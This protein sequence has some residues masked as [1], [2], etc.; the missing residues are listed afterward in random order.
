MHVCVHIVF[1]LLCFISHRR[2]LK[3]FNVEGFV[4]LIILYGVCV[5]LYRERG[6]LYFNIYKYSKNIY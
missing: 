2:R 3:K 5:C 1:I 4:K 6:R